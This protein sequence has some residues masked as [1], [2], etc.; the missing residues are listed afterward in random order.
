MRRPL[1]IARDPGAASALLPVARAGPADVI[2]LASAR[3]VFERGG[4]ACIGPDDDSN[5]DVVNRCLDQMR[6]DLMLTGTAREEEVLRDS[7]WW[8]A[9]RTR[10][11]PTVA[12]LDHWLGYRERFSALAPFDHLPDIVAVMD[13]Y[14]KERMIEFGCP[15]DRLMVTGQPALDALLDGELPSREEVRRRWGMDQEDWVIVFASEPVAH[16]MGDRLGYNEQKVLRMVLEAVRGLPATLIVKPHP[17]EAPDL[18][19]EVVWQSGVPVQFELHLT[20]RE[21][22]AGADTVMGMTSI[23]LVEAA[24]A[25]RPVLSVQ[26]ERSS[27]W[28]G[29]FPS[30]LTT[31]D[32]TAQIRQWL[33]ISANRHPLNSEARAARNAASGLAH[34]ATGRVWDLLGRLSRRD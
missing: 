34:G 33:S 21:T 8:S 23:F 31:V 25:G 13:E 5:P 6:P 1:I 26:P 18:L 24:L 17:R 28:T 12:L 30:L 20:S 9:G 11:I 10:R 7:Q 19:R 32:G 15:A 14:A 29:H 27:D 16:D 22:L 4:I 3:L 2:G